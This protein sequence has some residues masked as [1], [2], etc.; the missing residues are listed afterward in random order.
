MLSSGLESLTGRLDGDFKEWSRPPES[1][2]DLVEAWWNEAST[3]GVREPRAMTFGTVDASGVPAARTIAAT[4]ISAGALVFAT[5]SYSAKSAQLLDCPF[6]SCHFYW[7]EAGR[8]LTLTG[9]ASRGSSELHDWL[10]A[11][12]PA[13]MD[14]LTSAAQQ[15]HDLDDNEELFAIARETVPPSKL[16]RPDH[17]VS[18]VV[19]YQTA[20]FWQAASDRLHRRL[21]FSLDNNIWSSRRLQP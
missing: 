9:T 5:T 3:L 19:T 17:F 8:Q 14:R 15:S 13:A 10:W 1:P 7:R 16:P 20:E 12:R 11:Q 2:H 6:A 18:I 4:S 21:R